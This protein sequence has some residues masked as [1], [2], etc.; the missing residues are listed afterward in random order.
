MVLVSDFCDM[1]TRVCIGFRLLG[2]NDMCLYWFQ[3]FG[4]WWHVLVLVSDFWNIMAR[5][6]I[7]FRLLGHNDMCLYWFQTSG[8]WWHVFVLVSDF[9]DTA[10]Q[11]R[12]NNMHPS[13]YH[14]AHA[15]ILVTRP[16]KTSQYLMFLLYNNLMLTLS[17]LILWTIF[18]PL[19]FEEWW[20]GIK[21]YPCPCM[22]SSVRPK[23]CV[24][25]I[26]FERLHRFYSNLVYL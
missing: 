1:M 10:G 20:R 3:T 25:S 11:E 9:W 13:Y 7:G 15:C 19:P 2:H 5:V 22:H 24:R 16:C 23:F 14:Q 18:M 8:A 21:C 12:F 4:A 6:C 17:I 26:T